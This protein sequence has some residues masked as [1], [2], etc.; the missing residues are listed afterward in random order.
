MN[1]SNI[2]IR[3]LIIDFIDIAQV[4]VEESNKRLLLYNKK[5][6]NVTDYIYNENQKLFLLNTS[7]NRNYST[8]IIN[9]KIEEN[10]H[11]SENDQM[12]DKLFREFHQII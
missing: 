12:F 6:Y 9:E 2:S 5:K 3:P 4:F 8:Y 10:K 7:Q 11:I 1:M